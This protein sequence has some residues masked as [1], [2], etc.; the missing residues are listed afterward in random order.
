MANKL[1]KNTNAYRNLKKKLDAK[2]LALLDYI[3]YLDERIDLLIKTFNS[4]REQLQ[5][6]FK[7]VNDNRE[8]LQNLNDFMEMQSQINDMFAYKLGLERD[9][10]DRTTD[11]PV[12]GDNGAD[13]SV[14]PVDGL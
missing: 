14:V 7:A 10:Q 6:L 3:T 2:E 5:K 9:D 12:E 4:N 11:G 8:Q 13:D 1:V